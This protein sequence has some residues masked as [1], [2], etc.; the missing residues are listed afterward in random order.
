LKA[1]IPKDFP[2]FESPLESLPSPRRLMKNIFCS[3]PIQ[4]FSLKLCYGQRS[5]TK[6]LTSQKTKATKTSLQVPQVDISLFHQVL[7]NWAFK[8]QIIGLREKGDNMQWRKK[9]FNVS[10]N[11][12]WLC[13]HPSVKTAHEY[14]PVPLSHQFNVEIFDYGWIHHVPK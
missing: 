12:E 6:F 9:L 10:K 4:V 14:Q 7:E 3:F 2:H 11:G 8:W 13:L 1:S 5:G